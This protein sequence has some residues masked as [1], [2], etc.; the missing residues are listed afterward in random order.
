[1]RSVNINTNIGNNQVIPYPQ[2]LDVAFDSED[3]D[4][5][6]VTSDEEDSIDSPLQVKAVE[7][8]IDINQVLQVINNYYNTNYNQVT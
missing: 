4:F 2:A 7:M 8:D 3:E 1:M 5:I 6:D